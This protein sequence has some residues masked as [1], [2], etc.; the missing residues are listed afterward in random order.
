MTRSGPATMTGAPQGLVPVETVLT[1]GVVELAVATLQKVPVPA[2]GFGLTTTVTVWLLPL[3]TPPSAQV[4]SV[5][6][7]APCGSV[8]EP[9]VVAV[10]QEAGVVESTVNPGGRCSTTDTPAAVPVPV[11]ATVI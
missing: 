4:T 5:W 11:P 2:A 8:A 1:P 6:L 3:A 9:L 7:A 10:V